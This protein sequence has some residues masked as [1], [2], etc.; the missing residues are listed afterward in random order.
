MAPQCASNMPLEGI[1]HSIMKLLDDVGS[2][3]FKD[4]PIFKIRTESVKRCCAFDRQDLFLGPLIYSLLLAMRASM[5]LKNPEVMM[6]VVSR[7]IEEE[8]L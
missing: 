3:A 2:L 6:V 7:W 1:R 4:L 5:A 8:A